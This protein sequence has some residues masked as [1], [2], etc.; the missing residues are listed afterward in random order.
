MPGGLLGRHDHDVGVAT[1]PARVH[2]NGVEHRLRLVEPRYRRAHA[3]LPRRRACGPLGAARCLLS[4]PPPALVQQP[5]ASKEPWLFRPEYTRVMS[6]ALQLRHRLVPYLYSANVDSASDSGSPIVRPLYWAFPARPEAYEHPNQYVF[7]PALVVAPVV[8]PRDA[9][10]GRARVKV[11][12]PP[13]RHV[14]LFTGFAYD[15]DR[16]LDMYRTI[17]SFPVLAAEGSII[18]LD[19]EAAPANG[20]RNPGAFEVLV[21]VG[22]DGTFRI[23]EDPRDDKVTDDDLVIEPTGSADGEGDRIIEIKFDQAAGRL[24][25][26]AAGRQ[27]TFRFV[28]LVGTPGDVRVLADDSELAIDT[29]TVYLDDGHQGSPPGLVI[30]LPV[31]PKVPRQ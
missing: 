7:G 24:T 25:A 29:A 12:V 17:D 2:G 3:R 1:V 6:R 16:E 4:H 10:T 9:R 11:W 15:G 22:H 26:D 31:L 14:D 19:K 23:A 5:W 21:V 30:S 13:R 27:W 8:H 20:C 28:S 18:P